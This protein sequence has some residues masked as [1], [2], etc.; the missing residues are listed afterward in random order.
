MIYHDRKTT[1]DLLDSMAILIVFV[2]PSVNK[3][4]WA[5]QSFKVLMFIFH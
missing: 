1:D 3:C 2:G 5:V 4:N